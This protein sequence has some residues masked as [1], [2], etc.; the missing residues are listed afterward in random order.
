MFTGFTDILK[1]SEIMLNDIQAFILAGGAST[2]ELIARDHGLRSRWRSSRRD[3][4][5]S[6]VARL[7][8]GGPGRLRREGLGDE[9]RGS[10]DEEE[11]VGHG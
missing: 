5:R 3:F 2:I 8:R 9:C 11:S 6:G 10:E 4:G 1:I 7:L